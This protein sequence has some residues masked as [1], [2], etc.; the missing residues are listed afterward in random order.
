MGLL[1]LSEEMGSAKES[2][3]YGGGG[4]LHLIPW[5]QGKGCPLQLPLG[6]WPWGLPQDP[7]DGFASPLLSLLLGSGTSGSGRKLSACQ[8]LCSPVVL[9]L[10]R[11][12]K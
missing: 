12:F 1:F 8:G 10:G 4:S 7:K 9:G 3:C 5:L 2:Q 11:D 6:I